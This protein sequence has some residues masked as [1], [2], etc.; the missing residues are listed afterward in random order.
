MG[1]WGT[2]SPSNDYTMD[3]LVGCCKNINVP[4][5]TETNKCIRKNFDKKKSS[6]SLGIVIWFLNKKRKV[7]K[8]YLKDCLKVIEEEYKE[9]KLGWFNFE[10]RKKYLKAEKQMIESALENN[11]YSQYIYKNKVGDIISCGLSCVNREYTNLL[12]HI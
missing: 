9:N 4:S 3:I 7:A 6:A 1:A 12:E 2:E 8:K 10:R 5:Q 11:G